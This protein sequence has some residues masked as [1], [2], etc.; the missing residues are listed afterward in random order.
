MPIALSA[1]NRRKEVKEAAFS[2]GK[3]VML[4]RVAQPDMCFRKNRVYRQCC[5]TPLGP[6]RTWH[7]IKPVVE[8]PYGVVDE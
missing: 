3:L 2:L 5:C 7:F 8:G 6:A 1:F 4:Q